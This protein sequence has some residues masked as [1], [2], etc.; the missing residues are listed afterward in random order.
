MYTDAYTGNEVVS[1]YMDYAASAT[2]IRFTGRVEKPLKDGFRVRLIGKGEIILYSQKKV[3][4]SYSGQEC[5]IIFK[6]LVSTYAPGT[7][8]SNV[9]VSDTSITV[10]WYEKTLIECLQELC[11]A[12]GFDCYL[13][14]DLDW[15]FFSVNSYNNQD[16]GIVHDYNLIEPGFSFGKDLSQI[17]NRVQVIGADIGGIQ[18]LYTA[19]DF[20]SQQETYGTPAKPFIK[21][22]IVRDD[23]VSTY[24]QA[25][26]LGDYLLSQLKD[27]PDIGEGT[28]IMLLQIGFGKC[29]PL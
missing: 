24:T 26:E 15:R 10:T 18:V 28:S 2:T 9:D 4:A 21:T 25:Q 19:N 23:N 7:T 13:G 8:T 16:E 14:A 1:F 12:A 5:S 3:T 22:E 6:D 17:R 11:T 29:Y 20:T 27:P